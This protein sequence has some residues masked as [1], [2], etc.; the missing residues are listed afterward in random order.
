MSGCTGNITISADHYNCLCLSM[1]LIDK[2]WKFF[3]TMDTTG[4]RSFSPGTSI[5]VISMAPGSP[6]EHGVRRSSTTTSGLFHCDPR[7]LI[8]VCLCGHGQKL[9]QKETLDTEQLRFI[10]LYTEWGTIFFLSWMNNVCVVSPNVQ[11]VWELFTCVHKNLYL[12]YIL[13]GSAICT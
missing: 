11:A 12:L 13:K 2:H 7:T 9:R 10:Q 4:S 8:S 5:H 6:G 3:L 1:T